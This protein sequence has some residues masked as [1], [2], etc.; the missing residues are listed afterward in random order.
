MHKLARRP[1][2]VHA[3]GIRRR[4]A[5]AFSI[6]L[7][8]FYTLGTI[9]LMTGL[10]EGTLERRWGRGYM[11]SYRSPDTGA[12]VLPGDTVRNILTGLGTRWKQVEGLRK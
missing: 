10:S 8:R 12:K 5:Y 9:S 11:H 1:T 2:G 3:Q 7:D 4:N 6:D